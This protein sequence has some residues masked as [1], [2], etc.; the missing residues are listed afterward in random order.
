M[1]NLSGWIGIPVSGT[2]GQAA[3]QYL[4][5]SQASLPPPGAPQLVTGAACGCSAKSIAAEEGL[6]VALRGEPIWRTRE[7]S[8]LEAGEPALAVLRAYRLHG[9]EFIN[10]M[11]GNFAVIVV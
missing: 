4:R 7:A 11:F 9:N 1:F 3:A 2:A 8:I 10:F 6:V 5:E